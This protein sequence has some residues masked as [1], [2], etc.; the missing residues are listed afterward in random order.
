MTS[1]PQQ[2]MTGLGRRF[3]TV[4]FGAV[5]GLLLVASRA[6]A[7]DED[8]A[9]LPELHH[10]LTVAMQVHNDTALFDAVAL[11]DFVVIPPGGIIEPR[12]QALRRIR[13]FNS[14]SLDVAIQVS[15]RHDSTVVLVGTVAGGGLVRGPAPQFGKIRFM[16]VYVRTGGAWRLL[17]KSSTPCHEHAIQAGRC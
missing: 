2:T 1:N 11:D 14:D 3:G 8:L 9:E 15:A 13:N 4:V 17:A 16:A 12:Q 7:Q 5:L 6:T 10:E